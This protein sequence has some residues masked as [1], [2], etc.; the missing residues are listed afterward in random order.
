MKLIDI[1]DFESVSPAFR[2]KWGNRLAIFCMRLLGFEKVN[3]V[4]EGIS[5]HKGVEFT[6]RW[7]KKTGVNYIVGNAERLKHLPEGAFITVSNH[8]YGGL[9]G[10]IMID[11]M[12]RVRP[13]YKFMVNKILGL[14]KTMS[15]NFISVSPTGNKKTEVSATSLS[16]IRQTLKSLSGGH[17]IGFFPSGAVSDFSLKDMRVRDR[18]WQESVLNLIYHAKVPIIPIRFFDQNSTFFYFLGV[19]NW[20]IRLIRM[21]HELFNKSKKPHRL[22]IGD[23]ITVEEQKQFTTVKS[24]GEFLRKAVYDMPLPGKFTTVDQLDSF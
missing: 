12:V 9:D 18:E 11:L 17:P 5:H 4:Y 24:L 10:V 13:D 16:G 6:S 7:L 22:G 19:I 8:A 1:K 2:G 23:T 14:V 20:R 15:D 3:R 21:A